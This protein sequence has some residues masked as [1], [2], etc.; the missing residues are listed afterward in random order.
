[1]SSPSAQTLLDLEQLLVGRRT[2][3]K[4]RKA[5]ELVVRAQ[6]NPDFHVVLDFATDKELVIPCQVTDPKHEPNLTWTNPLDGSEMVWIPPGKFRFGPEKQV[7]ELPGFSLAKHPVSN[8]MFGEFLHE[9]TYTSHE[10]AET[11]DSDEGEYLNGGFCQHWS[12]TEVLDKKGDHPMVYVSYFDALAY[13]DWAGL[14]IP[15]EY[16]WEKA[17]RGTDGRIFPWGNATP[18]T[19]KRTST[20]RYQRVATHG[21]FLA[22][23]TAKVDK[24]PDVRSPYGCEQMAGNVSTWCQPGDEKKAGELPPFRPQ[25][26]MPTARKAEQAA[27]RG[28]AF[29]RQGA[30]TLRAFHRRRLSVI[31]RNDWVGIRPACFLPVRPA[32]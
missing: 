7:A 24:L 31:R 6:G 27:V 13:C 28:G 14:S 17:A 4:K 18:E 19:H 11:D 2:A 8:T 1:M 12:D 16:M 32:E 21:H 29:K 26:K 20:G 9:V 22:T 15:G 3:D 23:E 25:P 30:S 5:W 10:T